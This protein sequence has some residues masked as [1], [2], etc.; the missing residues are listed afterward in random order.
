MSARPSM[1]AGI[2]ETV[3]KEPVQGVEKG[4]KRGG[5]GSES[6]DKGS[7]RD[8]FGRGRKKKKKKDKKRK[9]RERRMMVGW[10][11]G[12]WVE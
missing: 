6:K 12:S 9:E 10:E 1:A 8:K 3:W 7:H 11:E 4:G 2:K 5:G